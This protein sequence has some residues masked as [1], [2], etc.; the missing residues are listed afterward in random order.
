MTRSRLRV[1]AFFGFSGISHL[2]F[3]RKF[4]E[5]IVPPWL[6]ASRKTVN[7]AAGVAELTGGALALI[8]GAEGR[9]RQYLVA[10][11]L[12]VYPANIHM[13]VRPQDSGSERIPSWLLW[14][15]LPLQF[16]LI[17]WVLKAPPVRSPDSTPTAP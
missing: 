15:R 9:A 11:L 12:A 3:G 16:V 14:A 1:A 10:L 8:P 4:F 7:Q 5:A 17:G 6:P 2:T 13:A